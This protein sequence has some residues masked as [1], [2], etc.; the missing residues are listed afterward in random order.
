MSVAELAPP[1]GAPAASARLIAAA[2]A[3]IAGLVVVWERTAYRQL[4]AVVAGRLS[5]SA[6]ASNALINRHTATFFLNVGTPDVFGVLVT[7][8]CSSAIVTALVLAVTAVVVA[9]TRFRFTRV[10][11]AAT[12][13]AGGF[14]ALNFVRL[15]LIAMAS[16]RWGMQA[17]YRWSHA[18]AGSFITVFGGFAA[19]AL[20]LVVLGGGPREDGVQRSQEVA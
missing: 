12:V 1:R 15:V 11:W 3:A 20:Y 18:W 19:A 17:G 16:D 2:M 7:P 14:A 4:E 6:T 10:L 5:Q 8:E 13:A 9:T